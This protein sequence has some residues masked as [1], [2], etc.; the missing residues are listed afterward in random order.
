MIS[1]EPGRGEGETPRGLRA[2]TTEKL[3]G[4]DL[5]EELV[6]AEGSLAVVQPHHKGGRFGESSLID[7]ESF[8]V[9]REGGEEGWRNSS[10]VNEVV[11]E[12][13]GE[14]ENGVALRG[15]G[16]KEPFAPC[17]TQLIV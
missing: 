1:K 2:V 4:G 3:G 6:E 11:H 10:F 5:V 12:L 13:G 7:P 14:W 16:H 17:V 8:D 9:G 15:D